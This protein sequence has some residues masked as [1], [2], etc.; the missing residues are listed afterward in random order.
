NRRQAPHHAPPPLTEAS[1][2]WRGQS[3]CYAMRGLAQCL[4]FPLSRQDDERPADL[5]VELRI[6]PEAKMHHA[7][8]IREER[9]GLR[10]I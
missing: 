1:A 10:S 6:G 2:D 4:A 9:S 7:A 5:G 3:V 8:L